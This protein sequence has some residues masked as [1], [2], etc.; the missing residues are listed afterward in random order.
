MSSTEHLP[1][2]RSKPDMPGGT[3]EYIRRK[4]AG[5]N[6]DCDCGQ[7]GR[8]IRDLMLAVEHMLTITDDTKIPEALRRLAYA[9]DNLG[10][11]MENVKR[12][13]PER[14]AFTLQIIRNSGGIDSAPLIWAWLL[15]ERDI[16]KDHHDLA[17][18]MLFD[19]AK[20]A[21]EGHDLAEGLDE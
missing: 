16:L 18:K 8:L 10:R 5:E 1:G 3:E 13:S 6:F 2:C 20:G 15:I 19:A 11:T 14:P 21:V 7:D 9:R 17:V 4:R 12:G